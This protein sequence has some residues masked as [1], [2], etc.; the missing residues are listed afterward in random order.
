[1][2]TCISLQ[3]KIKKQ[4]RKTYPDVD[5]ALISGHDKRRLQNANGGRSNGACC[6][7][8]RCRNEPC[9]GGVIDSTLLTPMPRNEDFLPIDPGFGVIVLADGVGTFMKK[10][11]F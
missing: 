11:G 10:T 6:T 1:M 7:G 8:E 9:R 2:S 4:K 5:V 3:Q